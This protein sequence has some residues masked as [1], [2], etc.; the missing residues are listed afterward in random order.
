MLHPVYP[1]FTERL[2]LRPFRD[3]DLDAFHAIQSRLDVVRYLYW[4]PGAARGRGVLGR[5]HRR[6]STRRRWPAPGG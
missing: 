4:S 3:D 5:R 1:L 2:V 6:R